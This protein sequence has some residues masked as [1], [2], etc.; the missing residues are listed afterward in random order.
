[1]KLR[2]LR[3][4]LSPGPSG[5]GRHSR[6]GASCP[7]PTWGTVCSHTAEQRTGPGGG[8]GGQGAYLGWAL[9]SLA[10]NTNIGIGRERSEPFQFTSPGLNMSGRAPPTD[11]SQPPIR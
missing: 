10:P 2:N 3:M 7:P 11:P 5:T 8:R 1:M 9:S 4:G 6:P